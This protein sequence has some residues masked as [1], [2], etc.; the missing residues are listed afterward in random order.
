MKKIISILLTFCISLTLITSINNFKVH[1]DEYSYGCNANEFEVSYIN[2]DGTFAK[3]SCH[4]N[5]NDAKK[6]MKQNEDYV[7]RYSKSYSPTRIVAMN[8][9]FAYTYPGRG[10]SSTMN[11][12][13]NLKARN[14]SR[15]KTTY[16]A[17]HYEM[18]YY[19]TCGP[20]VY[21][22]ANNGKGYIRV[23]L[24]G[25]E[26]Y[27]D[28][29]Y[30]DLVPRKF[31]DKQIPIWLGGRN[32]YEGEGSF[33]V[34]VQ[35]NY[36][37]IEKNDNYY[38]LVFYYYRAYPQNGVNGNKAM[39]A[40]Y[41]IDNA[42]NYLDMGMQVGVKYYSND[43]INFY[44][45]V[46]LKNKVCTCYN[47][48]EFLPLRTTT[49]IASNVFDSYIKDMKSSSSVL[50]NQ[51]QTFIDLQNAYGANALIVYSMACLESAYGTSGFA[52][53]RNNLFGWS[54]YDD[55]PN[56]ASYFSSVESCVKEQM[57]RNLN[58]FMDFTNSRYF[59]PYVG[60]KGAGINVKYAS[61]PYWGLKIASIAYSIDKYANNSNGKL[62][63]HNK[64]ELGFVLDNFN[65]VIYDA[66]TKWDSLF[67]KADT[68]DDVLYSGRYG[69]HYQ[70]DLIITI[71]E[72]NN[73]YKTNTTN[74]IENGE[75]N[76]EDGV[77]PYDWNN[78]VAY[79]NKDDVVLL[80]DINLPKND[81]IDNATFKPITSLRN[82]SITNNILNINGVGIIQGM[83]FT[84]IDNV[85]HEII[86][87]SMSDNSKVYTFKANS[88]DSDGFSLYDG[89]DYKYSG[90]NLDL[91]LNSNPIPLGSYQVE[92]HTKYKDKEVT[93]VLRSS[94]VEFRSISSTINDYT[95]LIKMN[96][97]YNYR[98]EIDLLSIPNELDVH[99]TLKPSARPSS[100][101]VDSIELSEEGV[102]SF[103]AHAYMFY[104][105]YDDVNN[106][107]YELFLID[108]SSN[109]KK[110]DCEL[111]DDGI[112]Y[113]SE[114]NSK[115]NINNISFKASAD[116]KDL[117]G[118]YIVYL[119]MS[120]NDDGSTRYMDVSEIIDYGYNLPS[121]TINDKTYEFIQSN[122]RKRIV[123][124]AY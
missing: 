52:T 67:Y 71:N 31:I 48:Y 9:G 107:K 33:K 36:F 101:S 86:F 39:S 92:L 121:I 24:N 94:M 84:K 2:D 80:K 45:D 19:D 95:Y 123:F 89:A 8:S 117:D 17:N 55:S 56:D 76:V 14:D 98:F 28:L 47:Y 23:T 15:Y 81:Y 114:L 77:L 21:D 32:V 5:F 85:S 78:S 13:Q 108:D 49:S 112:D 91:D 12:Y 93:S 79:L 41:R 27:T 106:I 74:P 110:I 6:A 90:F 61:D 7:V 10:N 65:D 62:T 59:G 83:N 11:L 29:E 102:L 3:V 75:L 57:G 64:Y 99:S 66:D 70:K 113:K 43:A 119:K 50:R 111:Y 35:Q 68:G 105:N 20:E 87:R 100:I 120:N 18:T 103:S 116:L 88:I 26:G 40:K 72:V 96:D 37:Q 122:I 104:L 124:N 42:K 1:A 63:D 54:A 46:N 82:V 97:Y 25:F 30:T 4:S 22:I 34:V 44:S 118:S 115:Y 16:V 51:G 73:R 53:A 38:D 58:W 109:Y 69:S 60:N